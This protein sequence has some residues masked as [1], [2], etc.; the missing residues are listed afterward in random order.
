MQNWYKRSLLKLA[1]QGEWWIMGGQAQ[2]AD[3]DVGDMN[4]SGYVIEHII[5]NHIDELNEILEQKGMDEAYESDQI[6]LDNFT[7]DELVAAGL[8]NEEIMAL[9]G[10]MDPRDYGM[11]HLG[12]KRVKGN[13]IQ[14]YTLTNDDLKEITN[15][16]WEADENCEN[17]EF[18]IEI[19]STN[20]VYRYIP[21]A[22]L[23]LDNVAELTPYSNQQETARFY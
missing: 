3:G 17:E 20:I 9:N 16:L 2:F 12:W 11:K 18:N 13:Y 10:S 23:I 19:G 15:G 22:V 4:H 21:W 1:I 14:T 7:R 5:S 8:S 6:D